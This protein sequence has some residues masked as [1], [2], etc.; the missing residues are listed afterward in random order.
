FR[1]GKRTRARLHPVTVIPR[2][3]RVTDRQAI[4]SAQETALDRSLQRARRW[5]DDRRT[6]SRVE[7]LDGRDRRATA[8]EAMTSA[9]LLVE[10]GVAAKVLDWRGHAH[11]RD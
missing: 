5:R 3:G 7:D 9:D 11:P 10:R 6:P 1:L 8:D 2:F 4:W